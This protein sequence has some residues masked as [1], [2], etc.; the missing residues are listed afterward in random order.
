MSVFRLSAW[1]TNPDA[2]MRTS[3]LLF[4]EPDKLADA[5][6]DQVDRFAVS[7]LLFPVSIHVRHANDFR[8]PAATPPPPPARQD[9]DANRAPSPPLP[10]GWACRHDFPP[11]TALV[12]PPARA[13]PGSIST[14]VLDCHRIVAD[15]ASWDPILP[16]AASTM[17]PQFVKG[18]RVYLL[19]WAPL[20]AKSPTRPQFKRRLRPPW[21]SAA[22]QLSIP[23]HPS[24]A[25][26]AP[27]L[28]PCA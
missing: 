5:N 8:F 27:S 21:P 1:T 14:S 7:M 11:P 9:G 3:E 25:Q 4:A 23:S 22:H 19:T 15:K 12:A 18:C 2:I 26:R 6:P 13:Q 17:G 20:R 16:L 28:I 24:T 10:E